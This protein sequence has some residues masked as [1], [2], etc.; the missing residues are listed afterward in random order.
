[1]KALFDRLEQEKKQ[2]SAG[3][4]QAGGNSSPKFSFS[5]ECMP[6]VELM[7]VGETVDLSV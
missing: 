2:A 3:N 7:D 5:V 6:E 4:Y 1:M